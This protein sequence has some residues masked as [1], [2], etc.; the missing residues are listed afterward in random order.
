MQHEGTRS[1]YMRVEAPPLAV[2]GEQIGVRLLIFNYYYQDL[3][4]SLKCQI[5]FLLIVYF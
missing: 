2:K 3:E 4:V 1:I 5:F